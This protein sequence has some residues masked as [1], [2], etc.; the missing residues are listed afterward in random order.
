MGAAALVFLLYSKILLQRLLN[1]L[2]MRGDDQPLAKTGPLWIVLLGMLVVSTLGLSD[3]TETVGSVPAGLPELK[4][5]SMNLALWLALLPSAAVIAVITYIESYSIGATLAA[6]EREQVR[7]NQELIAL[8]AAN[9]GAAV[10]SAY[11]VAGSFSRSGVNYAAGAR[12]PVSSI[13]CAVMIMGTLLF[14]TDAF[15]N[16]PKAALAA[17]VMVSVLNLID[18]DSWRN[19]WN[20]YRQDCWTEWGTTLAV[21]AFGIEVG[22]AIGRASIHSLFFAR[23]QQTRDHPNWS[24]W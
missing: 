17:I 21:L 1:L 19:N 23:R 3:T 13:V 16:L 7:P 22:S 6:K 24:S 12:S 20:T 9:I 14:F 18:L 2:G 11:P 10:S 4:W 8:S 5:P 15:A